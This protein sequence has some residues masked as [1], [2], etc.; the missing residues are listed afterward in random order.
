MI[1]RHFSL[2]AGVC[3]LESSRCAKS[4]RR[5]PPSVRVPASPSLPFLIYFFWDLTP[6]R[7]PSAGGRFSPSEPGLPDRCSAAE[8][9]DPAQR[10][11]PA[12][13]V[14]LLN[15]RRKGESAE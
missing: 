13:R 15:G 8:H 11:G 1:K 14:Q 12:L 6:G 4:A 5:S 10:F 3:V 9:Q 2:N 7:V